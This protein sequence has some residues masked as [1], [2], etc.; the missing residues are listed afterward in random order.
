MGYRPGRSHTKPCS[1]AL[2]LGWPWWKA[3]RT[4]RWENLGLKMIRPLLLEGLGDKQLHEA[5]EPWEER[6]LVVKEPGVELDNHNDDVTTD[7]GAGP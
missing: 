1:P 5:G 4:E 2:E 6:D 3:S 7:D